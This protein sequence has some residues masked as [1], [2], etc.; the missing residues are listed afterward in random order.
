MCW[1]A[2]GKT[3]LISTDWVKK[4]GLHRFLLNESAHMNVRTRLTAA[5]FSPQIMFFVEATEDK[6]MEAIMLLKQSLFD[7]EF[8]EE[9][10]KTV[11][12]QLLNSIPS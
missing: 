1:A 2:W 7:V 10:A 8:T 5:A 3:V 11:I 12:S 6:Y 4:V 9:R